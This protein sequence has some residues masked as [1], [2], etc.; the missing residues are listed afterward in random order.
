[1]QMI[2]KVLLLFTFSLFILHNAISQSWLWTRQGYSD[3]YT[4]T[5]AS[6]IAMDN[7]GYVWEVGIFYLP[8]IFATDT[9]LPTGN[10]NTFLCEYDNNG[11][12]LWVK[13]T[14]GNCICDGKDIAVDNSGNSYITGQFYQ[15]ANFGTHTLYAYQNEA[16]FLV[17][18]NSNGEVLWT[19]QATATN[20]YSN[21]VSVTTDGLGFEY[22]TGSFYGTAYFYSYHVTSINSAVFIAKYDSNGEAI[23]VAQSTGAGSAEATSIAYSNNGDEYITGYFN[24]SVN[25]GSY[26]LNTPV[27]DIFLVKYDKDGNVLWA[28]QSK[29]NPPTFSNRNYLGYCVA[30]DIYDNAYLTGSFMDS[31]SFNSHVLYWNKQTTNLFYSKF[32]PAGSNLWLKEATPIDSNNWYGFSISTDAKNHFY[33]SGGTDTTSFGKINFGNYKLN[34]DTTSLRGAT[35]IIKFDS[36]GNV[37]CGSIINNYNELFLKNKVISDTSGNYTYLSGTFADEDIKIGDTLLKYKGGDLPFIARWIG[38]TENGF[39]ALITGTPSH[40]S[41]SCNGSSMAYPNGGTAPYKFLWSDG[42]TTQNITGICPGKYS[43]VITDSADYKTSQTINIKDSFPSYAIPIDTII[44]K[45]Q[46]VILT[47]WGGKYYKW[48]PLASLNCSTCPNPTATPDVNT[49]YTVIISDSAGC[50]ITY[51][52]LVDV[53]QQCNEIYVPNVFSP[54]ANVNN[55]LYLRSDCVKNGEFIVYDRWGNKI[56]DTKDLN[57][58]WNGTYRG[59]PMNTETFVWYAKVN[60]YEGLTIIKKGNVT[61]IR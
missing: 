61:L 36:S 23:W 30:S 15:A 28:T 6:S 14:K 32:S 52:I 3:I 16:E 49:T 55:I 42:K 31:L 1:M 2:H 50:N 44:Y 27:Q 60:T 7:K 5:S 41:Y 20:A 10:G 59:Q 9:L 37:L 19:R 11:N 53:D 47:A 4:I 17:K 51:Q 24:G 21:G 25:F 13:Q 48:T 29:G 22:I 12:L 45:G 46:S 34:A 57:Q 38:C 18:Y 54:N 8:L 56:F 39:N 35:I 43:V 33:L 26:K 58:G 40:C